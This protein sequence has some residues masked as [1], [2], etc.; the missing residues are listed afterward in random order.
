PE[1][2]VT[3][4]WIWT[5]EGGPTKP[6][7][8]GDRWFRTKLK[9]GAPVTMATVGI[10]ADNS[11][12]ATLNGQPLVKG[13]GWDR[14]T[15]ADLTPF[16]KQ[17]ENELV[18]K[19]SNESE[20]YAGLAVLGEIQTGSGNVSYFATSAEWES[21]TDG[22]NWAPATTYIKMGEQPYGRHSWNASQTPPHLR[23]KF[24]VGKTVKKARVYA[25]A[26]G[27]Y[28]L[29]LD[30]KTVGTGLLSPGWTDYRK[31]IQYQTYDVTSMLKPGA[32]R[33][34]MML[35]DGWY[36][37]RIGWGHLNN[38]Y[39][40]T[41]SGLV[42]LE[43]E[44]TDG[45]KAQ[46]VSNERGNWEVTTGAILSS[47]FLAG[48]SYDARKELG[49]WSKPDHT[50]GKWEPAMV[51]PVTDNL[52]AQKGP[53]VEKF[54]EIKPKTITQP[55]AGTYVL[56]LGQNMVGWARLKMRGAAGQRVQLRFAEILNSDGT[57]YTTNL[58][59][60]EATDTYTFKGGGTE[61]WEPTFT[62][63][64]F[65]YVEVTGVTTA[66]TKDS[67]TG[68]VISSKTPRT[69]TFACSDPM[70]NQLQSNI[71]WGQRGNYIDVPTDCPQRDERLGWTADAQVFVRTATTNSDVSAFLTKWLDDVTDAQSEEG[72]FSDVAP[73]AVDLN[74]GAPGW[75]DAG[76]IVPWTVYKVYGDRRILERKYESMK[77]WVGYIEKENPEGLW[78]KRR[79]NDFG[80]WLNVNSEPPKELLATAYYAYSTDIVAQS[81]RILGK[82]EEAERYEAL[83]AKIK[84]AFNEK[85]VA[86]DGRIAGDAQTGYILALRFNLL[87]Q[88]KRAAAERF[89]VENIMEKRKGHL[90]TGFLGVS[91][92]NPTLTGIGRSDVAY[93]LL[94]NDTYPSWG[95]SIRQGATTIWERW[96]GWTKEKGFQDPGM[97]SFNHY[98]LG[99]VG[100]WMMGTVA[101]IDMATPGY[102][103]IVIRPEPGGTVTWAKGSYDSIH[104]RIESSWKK[105]GNGLTLDVTVP[106]NTTATVYI[107]ASSV[108]AVTEG[109]TTAAQASGVRFLRMEKGKAVFEVGG[110]KYRFKTAS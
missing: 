2:A 67:I 57:L 16:L 48:E 46:V 34:G 79:N 99:S 6:A 56:D 89:L 49:D 26:K 11:F 7:P 109:G 73:R 14:Y 62:F 10:S 20:G 106:A 25:T 61:V 84:A 102:K 98:S 59:G 77:A 85:W 22:K 97:N 17:G 76:V 86:A 50:G 70:V 94:Q 29:M 37:G 66:P 28:R 3:P 92:I 78:S 108:E 101:G 27:L 36:A 33:I 4:V 40:E 31:R 47:D 35:G 91:Y 44:Y 15:K 18:V 23:T 42:Q 88:E 110:G 19:A 69:G 87:P 41:P 96:D 8:A 55:K 83:F 1:P 103:T 93:R 43:I 90:S 45:T 9:V 60:A 74:D 72:G 81:A 54:T 80:D 100:E 38:H 71:E 24:E 75:G 51:Q 95:Y 105:V 107:P 12:E 82:T 63:H 30:G 39:G 32:H 65:R 64:G 13:E 58:R 52:V 5:N 68:I 21:S 53:E 104:G